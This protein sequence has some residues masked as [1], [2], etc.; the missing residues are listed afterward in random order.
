MAALIRARVLSPVDVVEA[1]IQR[2]EATHAAINAVVTPTFET[3]RR[4]AQQAAETLARGAVLGPLHGVP[5][6]AK[7]SLDV[8]GVRT[9][10]GLVSRAGH[11][12]DTDAVLVARMREAG[13]ILL[14]KTNVPDNCGDYETTN[15]LSGPTRNPWDVTR[16]AGGSSGGEA[17]I[18]AAGG[19][20]L[21]LGTDIAGS[22]RLPAHF[23]G[24][25]G[26]RPTSATLSNEG[27]WPP[28][29]GPLAE[30]NAIGPMARR[31]EDVALAFDVLHDCAP[32]PLDVDALRG[33]RVACWYGDGLLPASKAVRSGV[34]A[35][36][37]AL[38]QAGMMRVRGAV[39]ARRLAS[40]GWVRYL[41][42]VG[43]NAWAAGFGDGDVW[44]PLAELARVLAGQARVSNGALLNWLII[45]Y[46]YDLTRLMGIDGWQ[47][48]EQARA[49]MHDLVG[50]HGVVVCPV[51]PTT[52]PLLGWTIRTL[53]TLTTS[54]YTTWVN[55]AG[56]PGLT[57]PVGCAKQTGLP[58]GV[59]LV[60]APG[61]EHTLLAAGLAIQRAL[62]PVWSGP[63]DKSSI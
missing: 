2:I 62:L 1:H 45:H 6:T 8:A 57:V 7:D 27:Q 63:F 46:G 41:D 40:L 30:L 47:W 61:S 12:P 48:R 44:H 22:I 54:S 60:G 14:G 29:V 4:E 59:Q 34:R 55:L 51:F 53:S 11:M 43:R 26:L 19:S 3:A 32:Q 35:A 21:G 50:K 42:R 18:I 37:G 58:V 39:S 10:C 25:V 23:T 5:F 52:A 56:L 17:A 24:I 36:V 31:V 38:E 20:P 13:A 16:S 49:Q 9:T 28:T 15:L 33:E